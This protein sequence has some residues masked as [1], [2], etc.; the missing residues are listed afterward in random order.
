LNEYTQTF[1]QASREGRCRLGALG[2]FEISF[3]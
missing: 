3:L 2:F 1:G